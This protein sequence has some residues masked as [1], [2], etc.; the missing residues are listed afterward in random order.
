MTKFRNGEVLSRKAFLKLGLA[1][2]RRR[3]CSFFPDVW[4]KRKKATMTK[5]AR[6]TTS[7]AV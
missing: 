7:G 6:R 5:A 2:S 3:R 1:A 4:V